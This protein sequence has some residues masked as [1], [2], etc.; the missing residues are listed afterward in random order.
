MPLFEVY[1]RNTMAA[2]TSVSN[3]RERH[4]ESRGAKHSRSTALSAV[5]LLGSVDRREVWSA[6][7]P[8]QKAPLARRALS[9]RDHLVFIPLHYTRPPWMGRGRGRMTGHY[10]FMKIICSSGTSR[11]GNW[12]EIVLIVINHV[13]YRRLF[14]HRRSR[15][16]SNCQTSSS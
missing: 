2:G 8:A 9:R 16:P 15:N 14:I 4:P 10:A 12:A 3:Q 5:K 13:W 6:S 11:V 1:I 7:S